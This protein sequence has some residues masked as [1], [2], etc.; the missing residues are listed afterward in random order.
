MSSSKQIDLLR[1]FSAGFYLSKGPE[2]HIPRPPYTLYSIRVY[3]VLIHT[4]EE[5]GG[6]V[7]P[8]RKLEGQQFTKLG[9]KIPTWLTASPDYKL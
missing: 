7:E 1:D 8:E 4:G 5:G 2:P 3:S 6:R 9:R